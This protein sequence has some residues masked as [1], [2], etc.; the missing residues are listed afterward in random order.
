MVESTEDF[1]LF[2][3]FAPCCFKRVRL[4]LDCHNQTEK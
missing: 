1:G 2:F 4:S 3:M